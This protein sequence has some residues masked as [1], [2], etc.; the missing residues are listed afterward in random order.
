[1]NARQAR[2]SLV[3]GVVAALGTAAILWVW[4]ESTGNHMRWVSRKCMITSSAAGIS[5]Q[6]GDDFTRNPDLLLGYSRES[7]SRPERRSI[8]CFPRWRIVEIESNYVWLPM[9]FILSAFLSVMLLLWLVLMK[10]LA[11]PRITEGSCHGAGG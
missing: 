1:M 2:L 3:M 6:L 5:V 8:V 9:W 7:W 11:R 4:M 10:R